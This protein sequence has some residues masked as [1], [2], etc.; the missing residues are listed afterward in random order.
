LLPGIQDGDMM[1]AEQADVIMTRSGIGAN[2]GYR[3][4]RGKVRAAV[5]S[6]QLRSHATLAIRMLLA[7]LTTD[8]VTLRSTGGT[9]TAPYAL[10]PTFAAVLRPRDT[11]QPY[12]YAPKWALAPDSEH[13]L[14]SSADIPTLEGSSLNLIA[15]ATEAATPPYVRGAAATINTVYGL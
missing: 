12:L 6:I 2:A 9:A 10:L 8:G 14:L 11:T 5:L 3:M 7:H 1:F 15:C 4:R 13:F